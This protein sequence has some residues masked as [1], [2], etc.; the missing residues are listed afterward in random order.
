LQVDPLGF[1]SRWNSGGAWAGGGLSIP[2]IDVGMQWGLGR[3]RTGEPT[4]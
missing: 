4:E 3:S 1:A 2:P